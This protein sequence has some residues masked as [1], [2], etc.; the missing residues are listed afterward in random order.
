M[1]QTLQLK[2]NGP[3]T[4]HEVR[5]TIMLS[6]GH[7]FKYVYMFY[8]SATVQGSKTRKLHGNYP[9]INTMADI[10]WEEPTTFHLGCCTTNSCVQLI[11]FLRPLVNLNL[12]S[13][14][15]KT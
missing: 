4:E 6:Q 8:V 13:S 5:P 14:F 2:K 15:S 3:L 1:K 12:Q 7:H 11:T 10:Y 9:S